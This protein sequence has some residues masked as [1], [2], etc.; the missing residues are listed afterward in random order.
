MGAHFHKLY[1]ELAGVLQLNLEKRITNARE[2][3]VEEQKPLA[4]PAQFTADGKHVVIPTNYANRGMFALPNKAARG[5]VK[6]GRGGG[7]K[8][9]PLS[10]SGCF[11]GDGRP[12]CGYK[13]GEPS[14][15][16]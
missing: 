15:P 12:I 8:F 13:A 11:N 6:S 10:I 1:A 14:S 9:D 16:R 5:S 4:I 7:A 3:G 2:D